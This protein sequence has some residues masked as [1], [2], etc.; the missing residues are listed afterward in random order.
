MY[1]CSLRY[2]V[3]R[4]TLLQVVLEAFVWI[5]D[6]DERVDGDRETEEMAE[7]RVVDPP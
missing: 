7:E 3:C 5:V 4:C 1:S 6:V 2:L